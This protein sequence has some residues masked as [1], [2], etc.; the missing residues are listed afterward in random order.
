MIFRPLPLRPTSGN[1]PTHLHHQLFKV[2]LS[3]EACS[4]LGMIPCDFLTIDEVMSYYNFQANF[5]KHD[6]SPMSP[7]I[8]SKFSLVERPALN[9]VWSLTTSPPS[10]NSYH[11]TMQH[12]VLAISNMLS[13]LPSTDTAAALS[14]NSH[15]QNQTPSPSLQPRKT[16][17]SYRPGS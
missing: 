15:H 5:W 17:R 1:M 4:E 8:H 2:F 14:T 11:W 13:T 12:Q 7:I 3:R 16:G 9:S 10:M 6:S